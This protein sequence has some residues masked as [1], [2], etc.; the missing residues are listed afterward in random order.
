M[1]FTPEQKKE[2]R[3]RP[4]VRLRQKQHTAKY[5]QMLAWVHC[6]PLSTIKHF[7]GITQDDSSLIFRIKEHE[8]NAIERAKVKKK[9]YTQLGRNDHPLVMNQCTVC[10]G[11]FT[12]KTRRLYC[13]KKKCKKRKETIRRRMHFKNGWQARVLNA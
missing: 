4:D 11:S 3:R 10:G 8:L 2:W 9:V 12:H 1:A 7:Q 6:V 5:Q 13:N